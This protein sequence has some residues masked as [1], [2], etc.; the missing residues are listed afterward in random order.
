MVDV[1]ASVT[2]SRNPYS[3]GDANFLPV[4]HPLNVLWRLLYMTLA[5]WGLH[6]FRA[7]HKILHDPKMRHEVCNPKYSSCYLIFA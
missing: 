7:Y 2:T 1:E 6:H 3:G 5:L 4:Y